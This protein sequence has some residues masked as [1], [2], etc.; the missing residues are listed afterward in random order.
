MYNLG[1]E[2]FSHFSF[3]LRP[4]TELNIIATLGNC[5]PLGEVGYRELSPV[6]YRQYATDGTVILTEPSAL[7]A[8]KP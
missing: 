7:L 5:H 6:K 1:F 2:V 4:L 8:Q 3:G